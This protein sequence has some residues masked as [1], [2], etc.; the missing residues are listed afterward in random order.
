MNHKKIDKKDPLKNPKLQRTPTT[1]NA[2]S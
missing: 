2:V 1:F